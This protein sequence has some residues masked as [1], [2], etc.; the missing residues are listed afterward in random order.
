M[1]KYATLWRCRQRERMFLTR[2]RDIQ[3]RTH[4]A[5]CVGLDPVVERLPA[6]L[7]RLPLKERL[8]IFNR[9]IIEATYPYTSAYKI[10]LAFFEVH[11]HEGWKVLEQTRALI[12]SDRLV[13]L[14]AKR[15]DIGHS[16][17]FYAR[18]LFEHLEGDACTVSP[19][20]GAD[21][22]QPFLAYPGRAAFILALT[23]NPGSADLQQQFIG[24]I[25]VF[26]YVAKKVAE[27]Q[28][29]MP[30]TAGLVAGATQEAHLL[31]LHAH[32]EPRCPFLIP[33]IGAQ[34][35]NI[36]A[37][38]ALL[39]TR[40]V[41]VSSSRQILYARTDAQFAEAAATEARRLAELLRIP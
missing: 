40:P 41:L 20:M 15:G 1:L 23:S 28:K 25:P 13:I 7:Q 32:T 10:N 22:V 2:L 35:G 38:H 37:V 33:G 29:N 27:W 17:T 34:G 6:P 24:N 4:S 30:G 9:A 11:G 21:S 16:A 5:L 14:D 19:Y 31:H 36:S 18:T 12:P 8:L 3:S 26:L 39:Q